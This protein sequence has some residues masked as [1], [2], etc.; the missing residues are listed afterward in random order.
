MSTPSADTPPSATEVL[1]FFNK[2]GVRPLLNEAVLAAALEFDHLSTY[3]S[4]LDSLWEVW[5]VIKRVAEARLLAQRR[6]AKDLEAGGAGGGKETP[7]DL[8]P[9]RHVLEQQLAAEPE[10]NSGGGEEAGTDGGNVGDHG[11]AAVP[12]ALVRDEVRRWR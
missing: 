2:V 10:A 9:R 7:P 1:A 3:E 6:T 12:N 8:E 11:D 4:L 5:K